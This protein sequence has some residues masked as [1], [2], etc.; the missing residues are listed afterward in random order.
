MSEANL[1]PMC[2]LDEVRRYQLPDG[3]E[4]FWMCPEC[5]ALWREGGDPRR[6][7]EVCLELFLAARGLERSRV[8]RLGTA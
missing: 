2:L 4:E 6:S 8:T 1:C 5:E 7:T 3:G